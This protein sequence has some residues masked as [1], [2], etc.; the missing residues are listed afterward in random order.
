MNSFSSIKRV[1]RV[2][3]PIG[4][5]VRWLSAGRTSILHMSVLW[6]TLSSVYV[7]VD[8][9]KIMHARDVF[10]TMSPVREMNTHAP[11]FSIRFSFLFFFSYPRPRFVNF[12]FL[13]VNEERK[14]T[15]RCP[16]EWCIEL[17][18]RVDLS[19]G[20][21]RERKET[22]DA[23]RRVNIRQLVTDPLTFLHAWIRGNKVNLPDQHGQRCLLS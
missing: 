6:M 16:L 21:T 20:L 14:N 23:I 1:L 3:S 10:E 22:R 15:A 9:R 17:A 19:F 7:Y 12:S 11:Q 18:Y 2:G 4:I 13:F 5:R 8:V